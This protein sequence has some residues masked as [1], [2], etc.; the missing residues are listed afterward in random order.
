MVECVGVEAI[1]LGL[2]I[3]DFVATKRRANGRGIWL[4]LA[5]HKRAADAI[6]IRTPC[7]YSFVVITFAGQ[8]KGSGALLTVYLSFES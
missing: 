1:E 4:K 6:G 5:V 7:R 8:I 3:E 2:R